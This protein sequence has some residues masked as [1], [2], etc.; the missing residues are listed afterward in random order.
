[1]PILRYIVWVGTSLLA[2]LFVANWLLPEPPQEADHE[3]IEKPVVRIASVQRPPDPVFIDTDQPTTVPPPMPSENA[4]PDLPLPL[5]A[6]ASVNPL[7]VTAGVDRKKP[8]DLKRQRAKVAT[9]QS[10]SVRT[11]VVASGDQAA[12]VPPNKLSFLDIVSGVGK[13]LLNLR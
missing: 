8:K 3:A 2:L 5:Q 13:G 9:F 6:Y 11:H 12:T 4:I 7:P 1:M 10:P